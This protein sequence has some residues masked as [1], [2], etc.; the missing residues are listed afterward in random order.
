MFD[1][2]KVERL[3]HK[4]FGAVHGSD[5]RTGITALA[6]CVAYCIHDA[7]EDADEVRAYVEKII[8]HTVKSLKV[9]QG[10]WGKLLAHL[11]TLH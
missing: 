8:K 11:M 9:Q 1:E 10:A 3:V 6:M 7:D 4:I 2:D 5:M